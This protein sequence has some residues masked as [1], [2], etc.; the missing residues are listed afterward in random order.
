MFLLKRL[1]VEKKPDIK[2][3]FSI[4]TLQTIYSSLQLLKNSLSDLS[5]LNFFKF[6][7]SDPA[8]ENDITRDVC[9]IQ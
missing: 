4:Q 5:N 9:A 3:H 6:F 8:E 2:T 7:Y 1:S